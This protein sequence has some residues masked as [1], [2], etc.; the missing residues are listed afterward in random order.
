MW[1][2]SRAKRLKRIKQRLVSAP[3]PVSV[4]PAIGAAAAA[5]CVPTGAPAGPI[6]AGPAST[7]ETVQPRAASQAATNSSRCCSRSQAVGASPP[8]HSSSSSLRL[9]ACSRDGHATIFLHFVLVVDA[10]GLDASMASAG[11]PT[12][13]GAAA[14]C[15]HTRAGGLARKCNCSPA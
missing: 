8:L 11:E 3:A 10:G 12:C 6:G 1:K 7:V 2:P 13:A 9:G 14:A 15:C 4:S 5:C